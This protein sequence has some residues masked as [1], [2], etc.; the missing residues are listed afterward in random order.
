MNKTVM[1]CKIHPFCSDVILMRF[2]SSSFW[3]WSRALVGIN[4]TSVFCLAFP[5]IAVG[6]STAL[7]RHFARHCCWHRNFQ[8]SPCSFHCD[9]EFVNVWFNKESSSQV[10]GI[11][12]LRFLDSPSLFCFF[13]CFGHKFPHIWPYI[14]R[15]RGFFCFLVSFTRTMYIL[16]VAFPSVEQMS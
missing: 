7:C 13:R 3:P 16:P 12:E 1:S 15:T 11:V 9:L 14:V 8:L 4:N 6:L 10:S 2:V 5:N